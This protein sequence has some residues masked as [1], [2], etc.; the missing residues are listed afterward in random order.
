MAP[1]AICETHVALTGA[2]PIGVSGQA[3]HV[4]VTSLSALLYEHM[5][6]R[7]IVASIGAMDDREIAAS[8]LEAARHGGRH[9]IS[10]LVKE[11][12]DLGF[13]SVKPSVQR[14]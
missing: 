2:G 14:R 10:D 4:I 8:P 11:V 9:G 6:E 1:A 13:G 3:A 7:D 5:F 12:L